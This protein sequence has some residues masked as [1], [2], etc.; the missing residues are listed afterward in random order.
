MPEVLPLACSWPI[1]LYS[2]PG[3][4]PVTH[5]CVEPCSSSTRSAPA[6]LCRRSTFC[7]MMG[8][9]QPR[10]CRQHIGQGVLKRGLHGADHILHGAGGPVQIHYLCHTAIRLMQS[11]PLANIVRVKCH[12]THTRVLLRAKK[13][14]SREQMLPR[15][16]PWCCCQACRNTVVHAHALAHERVPHLQPC[17][18]CMCIPWLMAAEGGPASKG[19]CPV[20][21]TLLRAGHELMGQGRAVQ[22]GKKDAKHKKHTLSSTP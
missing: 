22:T 20:A 16:S 10:A 18:C 1:Y 5:S 4:L 9:A 11:C 12:A 17:Q 21:C 19:A 8:P 6:R 14:H 15:P 13:A 3:P 2:L 7:V